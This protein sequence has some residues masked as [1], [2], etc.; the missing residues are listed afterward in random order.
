MEIKIQRTIPL[1]NLSNNK[2]EI[3]TLKILEIK[4]GNKSKTIELFDNSNIKK[5]DL[6]I[7][8]GEEKFALDNYLSNVINQENVINETPVLPFKPYSI[9]K[10]SVEDK[11]NL[12]EIKSKTIID[13]VKREKGFNYT[14]KDVYDEMQKKEELDLSD[15]NEAI[16]EALRIREVN[17]F[18]IPFDNTFLNEIKNKKQEEQIYLIGKF[19]FIEF[20]KKNNL[21]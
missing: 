16:K 13:K 4:N 11:W 3:K 2:S 9:K 20:L 1:I 12:N 18:S 15:E 6:E 10:R 7:L 5:S 17:K 21:N 19:A 14:I 8:T